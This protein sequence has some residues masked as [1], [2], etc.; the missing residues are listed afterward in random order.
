MAVYFLQAT[1][2]R[3][4]D[5]NV[6]EHLLRKGERDLKMLERMKAANFTSI[7]RPKS[8]ST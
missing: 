5:F 8:S 2:V 7:P 4:M 6:I 1:S 3:R